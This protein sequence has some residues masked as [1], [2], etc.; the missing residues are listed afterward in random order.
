MPVKVNLY[1]NAYGNYELDIYRAVRTETYGEDLGQTSWATGEESNQIPQL[2]E[3]TAG[4][5]V[6]EVGCGAG[7]YA[8][9][10]AQSIGCQ[11]VGLDINAHAMQTA[12]DLARQSGLASR[13]RFEQCDASQKLGFAEATFDAA[14]AND[15]LCHVPGRASLLGE[16][17]RVL[18]PGGRLLFSDALVVGG[19]VSQ[20]EIATRSSIGYYLFSPPGENERLITEAGFRMISASDTTANA[21]VIAKRWYAA[22]QKRASELTAAEGES[23]F[24]G[25]Q[26]FL[27]CVY[28]LTSEKR[29]RR[30]VY[31]A[32]RDA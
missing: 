10:L 12:N 25:V 16:L 11:V 23:S 4:S 3:L 21:A 14:F 22:R 17:F 28:T 31:L 9:R 32:A 13:V 27:D 29:L 6:L 20:E 30:Y 1:D 8:L 15:V 18:K 24:Q 2:L 7:Q 26:R 19:I 5:A